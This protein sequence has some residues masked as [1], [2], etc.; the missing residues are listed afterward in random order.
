MPPRSFRALFASATLVVLNA[1]SARAQSYARLDLGGFLEVG[2][3]AE[4]YA[5]VLQV[6]GMVPLTPWS[7][8]PFSPTQMA[9]LRPTAPH[10]WASRFAAPSDSA[11]LWLLRPAARLI[12][13]SAY[14]YQVGNG[15]TWSGRGFTGEVQAGVAAHWKM[16]SLQLAPLAFAAQNADFALA[17]NGF[18]NERRFADA[19]FPSNIDAPQRFGDGAYARFVPGTSSLTLDTHG[20]V[21]GLS[22]APQRWG[23]SRDYPLVLGPNAGGFPML[24]AGTS[25]PVN[26]WAIQAHARLVYGELGQSSFA[27]PDTGERRRFAAGVVGVITI[28]GVP[29]LEI[30]GSRFI[31]RPW[32]DINRNAFERPF[33]GVISG[34]RSKINQRD[35]NQTASVFVR[36]AVPAAKAE[37]YGELYREDFPGAFHQGTGT[38]VEK[39][40]DLSA[41]TLGFQRVF[42]FDNQ[43]M[44]V[45]RG[46]LVNGETS[47]QESLER[48]FNRPQPPYV[49]G[50]ELQGH[51][52]N[53]L[54]LGSPEAYG[55]AAWRIGLDDYT[56][57]GR[58]SF[59][60]ERSLRFDWL[61]TLPAIHPRIEPDV[62]YALRGEYVRFRGAQEI[63]IT[64]L[65]AI[66]LNRN[67]V[68][69]HD[70]FNL[71]VALSA[72]GWH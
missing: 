22:S 9:M 21:A 33:S 66:D 15:P 50:L 17:P 34:G 5:R 43:H 25:T 65:P 57:A 53:G 37:F 72:R 30:G 36:W 59:G 68:A 55:G 12:A 70:V 7:I 2:G 23:P 56:S 51:T 13:N 20:F 67:L 49:H 29:G 8:E 39:P 41:F 60:I 26:L 16:V 24:Y 35:E 27:P 61:P 42:V 52:S 10:P 58:R 28:R 32:D 14:P 54:I 18:T 4:R 69:K 64:V 46:E 71:T 44:R 19:R 47:H 11:R 62:I 48:G 31:H 6:A 63:G 40:D 1:V 45:I 3:E 38:L